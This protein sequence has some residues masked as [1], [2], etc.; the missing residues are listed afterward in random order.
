MK[1]RQQWFNR[2]N[3]VRKTI[4]KGTS[5]RPRML[6]FCSN[7]ALYVQII[8]D[9]KQVTVASVHSLKEKNGSTME[10]ARKIGTEVAKRAQEKKVQSI[11]FDR[12]GYQYHGKVKAIAEAAREAGLQF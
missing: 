6:V 3:R 12:N 11:V 10:T 5:L 9:E 4:G 1:K 2:K 8:D 7:R